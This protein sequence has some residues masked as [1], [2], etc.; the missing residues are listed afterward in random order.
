MRKNELLQQGRDVKLVL[1]TGKEIEGRVKIRSG[2][3]SIDNYSPKH[4]CVTIENSN[5]SIEISMSLIKDILGK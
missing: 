1:T 5:G 2:L 4:E 3:G